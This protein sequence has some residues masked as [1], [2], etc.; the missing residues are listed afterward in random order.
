MRYFPGILLLLSFHTVWCQNLTLDIQE[1][2]VLFREG[3]DSVLFYQAADKAQNGQHTRS[4]YIHPLYT[5]DGEV[6]TEDFPTDHPHH[7][8]IFWAWHQLYVGKKRIGD[9]WEIRDLKWEV[10]SVEEVPK[11][12]PEKSIKAQVVW[13]SPL[14]LNDKGNEKSLVSEYTTITVYPAEQ[15]YRQIDI[16]IALT[17][18]EPGTRIGGS[19]DEK[20][21]GGFS[22]R[23]RLV[24]DIIFTGPKGRVKPQLLPIKAGGWMD[25][26]GSLGRKGALAGITIISHPQNPGYPN[27]WIL[28]SKGS[29]QNAVYPFPGANAVSLSHVKPTILRYRLLIHNG[30]TTA[31]ISTLHKQ[32]EGGL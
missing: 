9:G 6:I 7:R 25:I 30:L 5:L 12:G 31:V 14:W 17:A 3:E 27:P 22:P 1:S 23:I 13:K 15:N 16:E 26:S 2:G 19:E 28:R 10:L 4:N 21:Y 11:K 24:E 8:G 32:Y 18:L 29:M 20:G